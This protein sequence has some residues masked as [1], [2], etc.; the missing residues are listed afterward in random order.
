MEL[1]G[2]RF[3]TGQNRKSAPRA[4]SSDSRCERY[5]VSIGVLL[6]L[7]LLTVP[8]LYEAEVLMSGS[9]KSWRLS[10]ILRLRAA[11]AARW[12]KGY[13]VFLLAFLAIALAPSASGRTYEAGIELILVVV[14]GQVA[15]WGLVLARSRR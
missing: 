14:G 5:N 8:F 2:P 13:L 3:T 7:N 6:F 9:D 1:Q 10:E 15:L 12:T 11:R 4:E